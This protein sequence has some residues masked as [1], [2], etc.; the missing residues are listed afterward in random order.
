MLTTTMDKYKLQTLLLVTA[1]PCAKG[2]LVTASPQSLVFHAVFHAYMCSLDQLHYI[3]W[4]SRQLCIDPRLLLVNFSCMWWL[5]RLLLKKTMLWDFPS[6]WRVS[7]VSRL[8]VA[9]NVDVV[10][11]IIKNL[12]GDYLQVFSR[13][14]SPLMPLKTWW[15]GVKLL[16]ELMRLFG[17][18]SA[19]YQLI[20]WVVWETSYPLPH[21]MWILTW[22][23]LV[24]WDTSWPQWV[25]LAIPQ[26]RC[27]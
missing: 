8:L 24:S 17:M 14:E 5:I 1:E 21:V 19:T 4:V 13:I 10:E 2:S 22:G 20:I 7:G 9:S 15:L 23:Q 27:C 25:V 12:G 3:W 16:I 18:C 26:M 11:S 6:L